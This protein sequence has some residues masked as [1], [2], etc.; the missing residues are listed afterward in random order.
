VNEKHEA[1]T[2]TNETLVWRLLCDQGTDSETC[3]I[4]K[5]QPKIEP[6]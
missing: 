5:Q 4:L 1:V 2:S 6:L 3:P